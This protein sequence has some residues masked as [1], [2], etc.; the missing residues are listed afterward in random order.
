MSIF[1][2]VDV[3]EDKAPAFIKRYW[4]SLHMDFARRQEVMDCWLETLKAERE[5]LSAATLALTLTQN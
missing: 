3:Q 5:N 2:F 1:D 4:P